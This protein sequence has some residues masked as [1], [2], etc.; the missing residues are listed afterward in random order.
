[1]QMEKVYLVHNVRD[2]MVTHW[3]FGSVAGGVCARFC[4][5]G[6]EVSSAASL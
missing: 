5:S 3:G 1:M 2:S 6:A 4:V